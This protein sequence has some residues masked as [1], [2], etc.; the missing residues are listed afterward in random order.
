MD[1]ERSDAL[2]VVDVQNDFLP[3]GALGVPRGDRVVEPINRI[4]PFF[5]YVIGTRDW[6][7]EEHPHFTDYGG[8]WP[9]H[10]LQE[11]AGA[12]FAPGLHVN[13]FDEVLSK[14]T[15]PPWH[16][17]SAFEGCNLAE[18]LHGRAIRRIFVCGLAT[19]YCV[20][21]TALAAAEA[22]FDT[23]VLLDAIAAVNVNPGDERA[24]LEELA[25]HGVQFANTTDLHSAAR[26]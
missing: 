10:C 12:A 4:M 22:G 16:G 14:G 24:A 13:E 26:A 7:P 8:P 2:I 1:V 25:S 11:T 3:G 6:H 5:D 20:R 19:D 9:Y 21:A 15:E 17:Y 18:R 23:I